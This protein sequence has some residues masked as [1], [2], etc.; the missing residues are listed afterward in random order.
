METL[1]TR[2]LRYDLILLYKIIHGLCS[3]KFDDYFSY[4][5]PK[6]NLRRNSLQIRFIYQNLHYKNQQ[7]QNVFF[8]RITKHW[9]KLPDHIV[10]ARNLSS[11]KYQLKLHSFT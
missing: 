9:N 6:Y 7:W 8:N 11:F 5:L 4:N 1:E 2:R 3:I 10:T